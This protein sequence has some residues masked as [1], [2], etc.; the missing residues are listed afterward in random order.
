ME[1]VDQAALAVNEGTE[2]GLLNG[3]RSIFAGGGV[4]CANELLG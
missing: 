4:D 3:A 1:T 2:G